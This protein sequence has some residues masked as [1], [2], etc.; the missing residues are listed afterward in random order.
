MYQNMA[1]K[2]LSVNKTESYCP[3]EGVGE[4]KSEE[5]S[6]GSEATGGETS[7][8]SRKERWVN[9]RGKIFFLIC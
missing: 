5:E 3:R 7:Q 8:N 2:S 4:T 6:N 1:T 9:G